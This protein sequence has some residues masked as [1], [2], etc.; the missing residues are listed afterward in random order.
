MWLCPQK[1]DADIMNL[2]I[3]ATLLGLLLVATLIFA[4]GCSF[5]QTPY[6]INDSENFTVSI[7]FDANGGTFTDNAPVIVDSYDI[8]AMT[9]NDDGKVEIPLLAPDDA[10]RGKDA[11][12]PVKNGCF[13]AGWYAQR[14]E[15]T[16]ENGNV[17]YTYAEPWDFAKDRVEADPNAQHTSEKPIFTLY[18]AWAPLYEIEFYALDSQ[19]AVG[20]YTFDP[21][22]DVQINVPA[23]NDETG[24][25]DM[26]KFPIREGYTFRG[27]Y[28]DAEGKD[29]VSTDTVVHP[30][31]LN[32][33]DGTATDHK[34]RLYVDYMEGEWYRIS[35]PEQFA[36]NFNL[37]GSYELLADLDFAEEIWP[38][39]M[40][41]GNFT[42]TIKGNGHTIKNVTVTQ[43]D[44][45]KPNAGLFGQ[46]AA[47][48]V[49]ENVTFENITLTVKKGARVA[50][51]AYGLLCGTLSEDA[52]LENVAISGQLQIDSGCYFATDDYVIGLLCGMGTPKL[53]YANI[54]CTAV[55]DT[56]ETVVITVTDNAVS[57]EF[58]T[59]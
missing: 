45:A 16:D 22:A 2:K 36:D 38:T 23:W 15:S 31:K 47:E 29:A 17:T 34:L 12:K 7:K 53:D 27:A 51:A 6:A 33:A 52:T 54:T 18:A 14:T 24:A 59:N 37:N 55:G 48:A 9:V 41:Y 40:M 3:K 32:A 43:T 13:L 5:E 57:A 8:S 28:Y 30:G 10:N 25:V 35:T 58:V 42:G 1:E 20:S 39:A 11:F 56:P 26:Y 19:E 46:L 49:L 50:G 44:N 21:K 4:A